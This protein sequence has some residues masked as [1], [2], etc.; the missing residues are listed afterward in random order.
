MNVQKVMYGKLP[1]DL[2]SAAVVLLSLHS[3]YVS[4]SDELDGIAY[5]MA[6]A[7]LRYYPSMERLRKA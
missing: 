4:L 5:Q 7:Y 3:E 6:L 2:S 1:N